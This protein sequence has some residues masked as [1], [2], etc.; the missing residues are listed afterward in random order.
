[1]FTKYD[2]NVRMST[3]LL[4]ETGIKY[5]ILALAEAVKV[6]GEIQLKALEIQKET[7]RCKQERLKISPV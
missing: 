5:A 1:M 6:H 7:E 4:G 2:E 3:D